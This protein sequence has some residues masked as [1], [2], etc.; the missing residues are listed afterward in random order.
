MQQLYTL[1]DIVFGRSTFNHLRF[2]HDPSS[3]HVHLLTYEIE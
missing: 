3:R 2:F 1:P